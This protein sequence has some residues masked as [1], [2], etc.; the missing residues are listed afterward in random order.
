MPGS[1]TYKTF[2][3]CCH[4]D[5]ETTFKLIVQVWLQALL[6]KSKLRSSHQHTATRAQRESHCLDHPHHQRPSTGLQASLRSSHSAEVTTRPQ[7]GMKSDHL[8]LWMSFKNLRGSF[9]MSLTPGS[10]SNVNMHLVYH[11]LRFCHWPQTVKRDR[12]QNWCVWSSGGHCQKCHWEFPTH[13]TASPH[14]ASCPSAS[15]SSWPYPGI[16]QLLTVV[17]S[18]SRLHRLHLSLEFP[19]IYKQ[20][21]S[22]DPLS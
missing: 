1:H 12:T 16:E 7:A 13:C 14:L 9:L 19:W 4:R 22:A 21:H 8:E 17:D 6:R 15:L 10:Q 20:G 3:P 18:H 2:P 11:L 5:S